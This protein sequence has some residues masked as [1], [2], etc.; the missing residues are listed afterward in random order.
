MSKDTLHAAGL[1]PSC[2][3]RSVT[4]DKYCS[5]CGF[6]L[7]GNDAQA[8]ADP[9]L[10]KTLPGGYR[11]VE[12]I[13]EGSMGRVYRGEQA[14]LGRSVAVKIMN[15]ALL[16]HPTMTDR[17]R[18]EARAASMLNHPNCMRVYDFGETPDK[19]PYIVMEL[20]HG[21]DLEILLR[22]TPFL[23]MPRVLD[24]TRQIL[25]ALEEAHD[26]GIVHRDLKP[27]NVFLMAQR[28]GGEL[29]KVVDFGLA[30]LRSAISGSTMTGLI[31]GTPAYMA[32]EQATASETDPRTDIYAV[33]VMLFEMIAGQTPFASDS[34]TELLRNQVFDE[35][36]RLA[37]IASERAIPGLQEVVDR[38]LAKTVADRFP[39][40]D[41][42]AAAI[43]QLAER[44]Q[45]STPPALKT[46]GECG[47]S[48]PVAARFCGECG[49]PAPRDSLPHP[50]LL[51]DSPSKAGALFSDSPS[52]QGALFPDSPTK[53]GA[54]A[55]P[56]S[57]DPGSPASNRVRIP[58]QSSARISVAPREDDG[59]NT[60]RMQWG[61]EDTGP[62]RRVDLRGDEPTSNPPPPERTSDRI[63]HHGAEEA[64][65]TAATLVHLEQVAAR[66]TESGD[67]HGAVRA[68]ER[69]IIHIKHDIDRG[70]L[71]DPLGAMTLFMGKLG[72]AHLAADDP[73]AAMN[74]LREAVSLMVPGAERVRVLLLLSRAAR[75]QGDDDTSAKYLRAAEDEAEER[76]SL[77]SAPPAAD[78][79]SG[80]TSGVNLHDRRSDTPAPSRRRS[81]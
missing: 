21:Q 19:R 53:P 3:H 8:D 63:S 70:E 71:D 10:G 6:P 17:F 25:R 48:F 36:P 5:E 7:D 45:T 62:R 33:G 44:K 78:L 15:A 59:T 35:P 52:K 58:S 49:A 51:S 76:M 2:G 40:A 34:P 23:P 41:A 27:A 1:C 18:T 22:D 69:A 73:D 72:E 80:R 75:E 30:K 11:I 64:G 81:M 46:C 57:V 29:V 55:S 24:I 67:P 74:A 50:Q 9:L 47:S 60:Y 77:S 61:R 14:N 13:A 26:K 28:G 31:C 56:S 39:S 68:L 38:A 79:E 20:L 65:E 43:A 12:F 66:R 54:T 4:G 32:P 42:F 16:A 37:T